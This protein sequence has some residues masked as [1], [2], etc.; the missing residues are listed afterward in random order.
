MANPLFKA[1]GNSQPIQNAGSPF[2]MFGGPQQF[3]QTLNNYAQNFM[4]NMACTPEQKVRELL[5][6]G[7]MTQ[8]QFN[9]LSSLANRLTGRN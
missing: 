4:S 9:Q 2:D 3:Q 8:E 1:F 7:R 6:S 5:D